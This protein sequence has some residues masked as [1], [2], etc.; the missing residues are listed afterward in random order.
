MVGTG[1][2]THSDLYDGNLIINKG[3]EIFKGREGKRFSLI[4]LDNSTGKEGEE[5][6]SFD[7]EKLLSNFEK[8]IELRKVD[9]KKYPLFGFLFAETR[10]ENFIELENILNSDLNEFISTQT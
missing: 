6:A 3:Q 4:V 7:Y 8:P 9:H 1:T 10:E 5:I 2:V